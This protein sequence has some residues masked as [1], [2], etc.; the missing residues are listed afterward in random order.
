MNFHTPEF[1]CKVKYNDLDHAIKNCLKL[2]QSGTIDIGEWQW[3]HQ[4]TQEGIVKL[5][6][7]SKTDIK[8]AFRLVPILPSQRGLL[9]M[10]A[11]NPKTNRIAYFADKCL[12]FG[13]S[14]SCSRFTEFSES[15]RHIIEV[16][17]GRYF[18][19][20]N[21][22]DDF[23]FIASEEGTCN[24]MVRRFI[25]ICEE[26]GC[27][28]AIEKTEWAA[29]HMIFLGLMLN[30]DSL[31]ISIPKE[32]K[33]KALYLLNAAIDRKKVTIRF[34]Q[35]LSG[36][37]N[38]LNRALVPGRAFTRRMYD[39]LKLKDQQGRPLKQYH[40]VNLGKPFLQDCKVWKYFLQNCEDNVAQLC[41][42]FIDLKCFETANTLNFYTDASLSKKH[43]GL[44]G[45]FGERWIM[46]KWNVQFLETASPS[47]E[48]L[49]LFALVAGI[50]TWGHLPALQNTR[51]IVFCDNKSS[52]DM[53]NSLTTNCPKCMK[54][55]RLLTMD[56][57]TNNRRVF[58]RY[59]KSKENSLADSLS[60][61]K[62]STFFRDAPEN[63]NKNADMIPKVLWPV[64]DFWSNDEI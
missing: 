60:R 11:K 22:L 15:L 43:G 10:R 25:L 57:I 5:I 32:K 48:F 13:A 58:V 36:T 8:S 27:P 51:I 16:Q 14:I 3:A 59:V 44:G 21:Y 39:K 6:Y 42:P 46:E 19:V 28:I 24:N 23:L 52:R 34:V 50:L 18:T 63:V 31:T 4:R 29:L 26:I 40:H 1:L 64:E 7:Y 62:M 55:I 54:L 61:G 17:T 33:D 47:I 30:G 56:N 45:I 38:F 37:L 12:P 41:R 53:V 2:L 35:Q 20:T 9:L 49:E